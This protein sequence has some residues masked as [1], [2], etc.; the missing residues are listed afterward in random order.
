M[1]S[2]TEEI[3]SNDGSQETK[4]EYSLEEIDVLCR[5][6]HHLHDEEILRILGRF[7]RKWANFFYKDEQAKHGSSTM[8][9]QH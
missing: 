6:Y 4:K 7:F 3:N 2:K 9:K 5:K 1:N 8:I